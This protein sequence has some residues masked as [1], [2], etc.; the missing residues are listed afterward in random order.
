M[1]WKSEEKEAFDHLK[2]LNLP[3]VAF[4]I[5]GQHNPNIPDIKVLKKNVFEFFID[6][7]MEDAQTS[8]FVVNIKHNRFEYSSLNKKENNCFK[9]KIVEHLNKNF[10]KYKSVKSKGIRINCDE[11][12]GF[13]HIISDLRSKGIRYIIT[14]KKNSDFKIICIDKL[15]SFFQIQGYLRRKKSGTTSVS[16]KDLHQVEKFL[17][18]KFDAFD[19]CFTDTKKFLF[20]SKHSS[21]LGHYL[22]INEDRY[23]VAKNKIDGYF[24]LNKTSKTNNPNVIFALNLVNIT[25]NDDRDSFLSD[26]NI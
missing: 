5:H 15:K 26:L 11:D 9:L 8:Q 3:N 24:R 6:V 1:S 12:T 21:L 2:K 22:D 7:K 25:N 10:D 14:R 13:G 17:I 23:F 20:K 4:E 18:N 19:I 16:E